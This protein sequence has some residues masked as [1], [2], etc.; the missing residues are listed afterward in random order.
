MMQVV[1]LDMK[2]NAYPFSAP[3]YHPINNFLQTVTVE[4]YSASQHSTR[5]LDYQC[6]DVG[7]IG[8]IPSYLPSSNLGWGD[9]DL[10]LLAT[11]IASQLPYV[12]ICIARRGSQ[13]QS[14]CSTTQRRHHTRRCQPRVLN[15]SIPPSKS[16]ITRHS[17]L[18]C[19]SWLALDR[20]PHAR[21]QPEAELCV[22][23]SC[24]SSCKHK[25]DISLFLGCPSQRNGVAN[26]ARAMKVLHHVKLQ[27]LPNL[28]PST[29][30]L[31]LLQALQPVRL[32]WMNLGMLNRP[33]VWVL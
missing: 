16:S 4:A 23:P 24:C 26:G 21:L 10:V 12:V 31:L 11:A 20:Q 28:L 3:V 32:G 29:T 5:S 13:L 19:T 22:T 15:P 27:F 8:L 6:R 2:R 9:V 25:F 18:T 7:S 14:A 1:V 33:K 30:T 17:L